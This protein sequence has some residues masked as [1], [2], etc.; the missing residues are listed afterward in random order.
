[1]GED[2]FSRLPDQDI[3]IRSQERTCDGAD[4]HVLIEQTYVLEGS[5]VDKEGPDTGLEVGPGEFVWRPAGSRHVAWCPKGGTMIAIFQVPNRFFEKDGKVT[6]A[7]GKDW[8]SSW[9]HILSN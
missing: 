1:V 9:G 3:A 6:D 5:L 4:E 7:G 2:A 8:Q